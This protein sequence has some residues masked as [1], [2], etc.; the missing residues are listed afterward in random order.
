MIYGAPNVHFFD[1]QTGVLFQ[2]GNIKDF[3]NYTDWKVAHDFTNNQFY[4]FK[5]S[6]DDKRME[7]FTINN[8]KKSEVSSGFVKEYLQKRITSFKDFIF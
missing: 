6:S 3:G 5:C 2:K 8:F 7:Q 1:L 4:T